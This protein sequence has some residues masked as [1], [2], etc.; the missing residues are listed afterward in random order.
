MAK[1]PSIFNLSTFI[2]SY[3]YLNIELKY[4]R[5]RKPPMLDASLFI[6]T[7]GSEGGCFPWLAFR[8]SEPGGVGCVLGA[9]PRTPYMISFIRATS[10]PYGH[11]RGVTA[12]FSTLRRVLLTF[13][14]PIF[15]FCRTP[16]GGLFCRLMR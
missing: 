7:S 1:L 16:L 13:K 11:F 4:V 9:T 3:L 2:Y 12:S 8:T 15:L 14:I 5:S 10:A 6:H